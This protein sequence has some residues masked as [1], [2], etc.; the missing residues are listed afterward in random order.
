[1]K[2]PLLTPEIRELLDA[3]DLPTLVEVCSE[4]HP[5]TVAEVLGDLDPAERLRVLAPLPASLR[6]DIVSEMDLEE[7]AELAD[8]ASAKELASFLDEMLADDRVDFVQRLDPGV[9]D[10]VLP[11]LERAARED[12]KRLLAQAEGTV[13]ARMNTDFAKIPPGLTASQAIGR[14]RQQAS[15]KETIYY[16]YVVDDADR[17]LGVVSLK[18]LVLAKPETPVSDIM[19]T[20]L[21]SVRASEDQEAAAKILNS[22]DLLALP[23]VD[24]QHRIVGILTYDDVAD[25]VQAEATEDIARIGA[26]AAG[27]E[28]EPYLRTGVMEHVRRRM[29]WIVVLAFLQILTSWVIGA[30]EGAIGSALILAAYIPMV[31]ATGGNIGAQ[32]STVLIRS[33]ALGQVSTGD[34]WRVAMRELSI[35]G[36]LA[37][38]TVAV[39][40]IKVYFFTASSQVPAGIE[41]GH[42]AL[43]VAA[44]IAAQTLTSA[45]V[46]GLLP[47]GAKAVGIDPAV[48]ATPA[49]TTIVDVSGLVIYFSVAV[50]FLGLAT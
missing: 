40:F 1:V 35:A 5:R 25:I 30:Y 20:E 42:I 17:M 15:R 9:R 7:Q 46:G 24:D 48:V 37:I 44:A 32:S 6:A 8:E 38:A 14:L 2:N 28:D 45:F 13:G 10:Q 49:I 4:M 33:I 12:V 43:V 47:L 3:S 18:E 36:V 16:S 19:S 21:V 26:V 41:L 34:W 31:M 39:A 27:A 50:R 23:V 29:G 22:Y 11:L